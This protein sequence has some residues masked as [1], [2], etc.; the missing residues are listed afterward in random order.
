MYNNV[1][2]PRGLFMAAVA[3]G[4]QQ[5]FRPSGGGGG[6]RHAAAAAFGNRGENVALHGRGVDGGL[7]HLRGW[8]IIYN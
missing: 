5:T 1:T 7:A 2:A 6:V 8:I 3:L 4:D